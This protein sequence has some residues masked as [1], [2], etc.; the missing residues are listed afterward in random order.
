MEYLRGLYDAEITHVDHWLRWLFQSVE[1]GGLLKNTVVVITSDHGE[2]FYEHDYLLHGQG[3]YQELMHVPLL[4]REPGQTRGRRVDTPVSLVDVPVTVLSFCGLPTA[5]FDRGGGLDLL[6]PAMGSAGER[7]ILMAA[8]GLQ[9]TTALPG[10]GPKRGLRLGSWKYIE[11]LSE[12]RIELFDLSKDPAEMH[13][14]ASSHPH[15]VASIASQLDSL[16]Q[17]LGARALD[18]V[19]IDPVLLEKMKALGYVE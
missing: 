14:L 5:G 18:D 15:I 1:A 12:D 11:F 7:P 4:V 6:D 17:H 3:L 13:D 8:T 19:E 9:T 2:E 10:L 16:E